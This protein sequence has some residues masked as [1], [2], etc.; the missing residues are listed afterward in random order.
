[1]TL[2]TISTREPKN[3]RVWVVIEPVAMI[4]LRNVVRRVVENSRLL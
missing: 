3:T 4:G 2:F 1:M